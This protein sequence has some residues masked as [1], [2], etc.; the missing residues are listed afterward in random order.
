MT[1][2]KKSILI[3]IFLLFFLGIFLN[4]KAA[5]KIRSCCKLDNT[6]KVTIK[7]K[8][9]ECEM[10]SLL[11]PNMDSASVCGTATLGDCDGGTN[12]YCK[13]VY[14]SPPSSCPG[15]TSPGLWATFCLL[16][17][18]TNATN[19]LFRILVIGSSVMIIAGS[20][21]IIYSSGDTKK[22]STGRNFILYSLIALIVGLFAKAIPSIASLLLGMKY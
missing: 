22:W 20:I 12:Q 6:I 19:L 7:G 4:A 14:N 13:N 10:G 9:I 15:T 1:R 11:G 2:K 18:I 8:Q 21:F 16:D 5:L 17:A 3:F